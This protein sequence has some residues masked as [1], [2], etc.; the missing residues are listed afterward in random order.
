[1]CYGHDCTTR[2][3]GGWDN[4]RHNAVWWYGSA[5]FIGWYR[6]IVSMA[7][8]HGKHSSIGMPSIVQTL[9]CGSDRT[10]FFLGGS[11]VHPAVIA[12]AVQ[13]AGAYTLELGSL[14]VWEQFLPAGYYDYPKLLRAKN[15]T[16]LRGWSGSAHQGPVVGVRLIRSPAVEGKFAY[17]RT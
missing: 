5:L 16:V 13:N 12:N 8:P 10:S 7:A 15:G 3:V 14:A 1:M 17:I 4:V 9:A 2:I 11:G 6:V